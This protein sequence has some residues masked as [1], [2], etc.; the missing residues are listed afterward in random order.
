M[1]YKMQFCNKLFCISFFTHFPKT[2]WKFAMLLNKVF[3]K[4]KSV[5]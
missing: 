4:I 3:D 5:T 2:E 1:L